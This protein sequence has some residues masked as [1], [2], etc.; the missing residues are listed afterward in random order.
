[1]TM[2]FDL[3]TVADGLWLENFDFWTPAPT[4]RGAKDIVS[5]LTTWSIS[6]RMKATV[7]C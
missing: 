1:M 7:Q 4:V 3:S 6:H 2:D 5:N